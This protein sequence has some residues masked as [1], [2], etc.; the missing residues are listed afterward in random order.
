MGK[1]FFAV[2]LVEVPTKSSEKLTLL[3]LSRQRKDSLLPSL[4]MIS[5]FSGTFVRIEFISTL[6]TWISLFNA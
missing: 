3:S 5:M 4:L 1:I 6:E 2:L